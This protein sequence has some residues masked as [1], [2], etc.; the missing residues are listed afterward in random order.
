MHMYGRG[1]L[2]YVATLTTLW[3]GREVWLSDHIAVHNIPAG[4]GG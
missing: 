1:G 3:G 2:S 4:G